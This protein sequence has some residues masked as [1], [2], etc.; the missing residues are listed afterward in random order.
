MR[1]HWLSGTRKLNRHY[2][3]GG[4]KKP[5]AEW[6]SLDIVE[7]GFPYDYWVVTDDIGISYG[8]GGDY[9]MP[10][11]LK[12]VQKFKIIHEI[13]VVQPCSVQ[14]P[15]F[16]VEWVT[17]RARNSTGVQNQIIKQWWCQNNP[18]APAGSLPLVQSVVT[19]PYGGT[20]YGE[21]MN[22]NPQT[23]RYEMQTVI[24][25]DKNIDYA[26]WG[27]D[28]DLTYFRAAIQ[29]ASSSHFVQGDTVNYYGRIERV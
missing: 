15:L 2:Q 16:Y 27:N 28:K 29:L 22:Y 14:S 18:Y 8:G 25:I 11:G 24:E 1:G 21:I 9:P 17:T 20:S 12:T 4:K 23:G 7:S 3:S 13:E 5:L 26:S 10:A 6:E 19:D